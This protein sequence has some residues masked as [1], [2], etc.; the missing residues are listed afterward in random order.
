[1]PYHPGSELARISLLAEGLIGISESSHGALER[2]D[3]ASTALRTGVPDAKG[4]FNF[5]HTATHD[6][7]D[8]L[9][10]VG[11]RPG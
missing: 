4:Q 11:N 6:K 5:A 2:D 7:I 8:I 1:M 9:S 10:C 3:H